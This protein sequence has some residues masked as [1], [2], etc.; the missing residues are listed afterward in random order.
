MTCYSD[1]IRHIFVARPV[2][3]KIIIEPLLLQV[4]VYRIHIHTAAAD[5]AGPQIVEHRLRVGIKALDILI[6]R[7]SI[8]GWPPYKQTASAL[9]RQGKLDAIY[10]NIA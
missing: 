2:N 4:I 6:I 3:G 10:C 8:A 5:L 9:I 7:W 1:A